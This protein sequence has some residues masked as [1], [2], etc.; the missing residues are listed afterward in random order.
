M[1]TLIAWIFGLYTSHQMSENTRRVRQDQSEK[2]RVYYQKV[3]DEMHR[4]GTLPPN[5]NLRL[6][7]ASVVVTDEKG[8]IV[9]EDGEWKRLPNDGEPLTISYK[10]ES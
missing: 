9:A 1:K 4:N 2:S 6:P 3:V 8:E 7:K 10:K 5:V